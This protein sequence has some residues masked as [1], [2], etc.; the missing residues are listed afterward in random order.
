MKADTKKK[1]INEAGLFALEQGLKGPQREYY[2]GQLS[3]LRS[4]MFYAY[5]P[6]ACATLDGYIDSLIRSKGF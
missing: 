6:S 4:A 3:G 5:G 2:L 1:L